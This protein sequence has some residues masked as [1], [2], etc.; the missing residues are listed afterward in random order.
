MTCK[1][2]GEIMNGRN[3]YSFMKKLVI[4]LYVTQIFSNNVIWAHLNII[5][6]LEQ[7]IPFEKRERLKKTVTT[8]FIKNYSNCIPEMIKLNKI[9]Q[10]NYWI[11]DRNSQDRS[12]STQKQLEETIKNF[13]TLVC[14][15]KFQEIIFN[16]CS[17]LNEDGS[18]LFLENLKLMIKK[19]DK[20]TSNTQKTLKTNINN[21]LN[22]NN[23]LLNDVILLIQKIIQKE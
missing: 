20:K 22:Q 4:I 23:D 8:F 5:S 6:K 2:S 16:L 9:W 3:Y 7:A 21:L 19:I 11:S 12:S 10:E 1:K 18:I 13:L 15:T 17:Y 14:L